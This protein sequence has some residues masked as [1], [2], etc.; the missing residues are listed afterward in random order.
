MAWL[1]MPPD[2]VDGMRWCLHFHDEKR[3]ELWHLRHHM[4][5]AAAGVPGERET[6]NG[7]NK[8]DFGGQVAD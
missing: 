5:D 7:F 6:R 8:V 4:L 3:T 1:L 2:L